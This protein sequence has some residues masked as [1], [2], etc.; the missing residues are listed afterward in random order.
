MGAFW[1]SARLGG[2]Q[3]RLAWLAFPARRL[4][5]SRVSF[6][7]QRLLLAARTIGAHGGDEEPKSIPAKV[8][9]GTSTPPPRQAPSH[10]EAATETP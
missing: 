8:L 10:R 3:A 6:C 1:V 9:K 4:H 7:V 5:A 2:A